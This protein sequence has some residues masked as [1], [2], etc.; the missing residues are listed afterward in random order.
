MKP[1][2]DA[3]IP[4]LTRFFSGSNALQWEQITGGTAPAT[5]LAS[6]TPWL[7][8]L[9]SSPIDRPLL[10]PVFAA[11]GTRRWYAIAANDQIATQLL[12]EVRAFIGPSFSRFSGH[13]HA[14]SD[15][16]D[17]ERVLKERFDW[18]VL[19]ID[20]NAETD[21]VNVERSIARY[22]DLLG[23]RPQIPD[24][25]LRPFA[26]VR[27]DFELALLAGNAERA[28]RF[29]DELLGSG[30]IG[31]DQHQF[32]RIR[33]LAGLG[34][35]EE[36]AHDRVLIASVMNLALPPQTLVDLVEGLYET[37]IEPRERQL[38]M[39]ALVA[40]FNQHL[41]RPFGALFR[42]RKGIRRPR[43]LRAF[44]LF[45]AGQ[46][47]RN[48]GRCGAIVETY[49][50]EDAALDL[51]QHWLRSIVP[52]GSGHHAERVRQAVA[53][54]DYP[55]ATSLALE[56]LPQ[57]WAY[58]AL[59]R[60]AREMESDELGAQL[61]EAVRH[62]DP[63]VLAALTERDRARHSRLTASATLPMRPLAE[64]GWLAWANEV[65]ARTD[66]WVPLEVLSKAVL[67]WDVSAYS[68]DPD[69][70]ARLAELIGNAVEPAARVFRDAFPYMVDFF[71][72]RLEKP[73]RGFIPLYSILIKVIAWSGSVSADELEI[74][75]SL[76][77]ALLAA[78]PDK[79]SYIECL[80]DL[81]EV[82]NANSAPIHLDWALSLAELLVLYPSH[83]PE[84]RLRLFFSIFGLCRAATHRLS[85]EQRAVL[86]LLA[87]DYGCPD[88]LAELPPGDR[89]DVADDPAAFAGLIGIYT[90]NEPAGQR[91]RAVIERLLPAV[92]VELNSDL[93]ASD[94]L[95]HL[96]RNADLFVFAWKTSTHQAFYCAKDA[97]KDR[98]IIMPSGGGTASLVKSVLQAVR[99]P[100]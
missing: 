12:E 59:L 22:R 87:T 39:S 5:W 65:T 19:R 23:Q 61:L 60:C 83:E 81:Q 41:S 18:R 6:V 24:R 91:A 79:A 44:F 89:G 10:L 21:R 32:L 72:E 90:L 70:C 34:R 67:K 57:P 26:V 58:S 15:S 43:V 94:R 54:E 68:T 56:A 36:L 20:L 80:E 40:L 3:E 97:R 95:R 35:I 73:I 78:G 63:I 74:G 85:Q 1:I 2:P 42:E 62:I 8:F 16:D 38:E 45:E 98:D 49:P 9:S 4:W 17:A 92:T 52:A 50:K 27:N 66:E 86:E 75:T 64:S 77:R 30:R 96:A 82:V 69:T 51:V 88:L 33:F 37:Y 7:G 84:L 76:T 48:D 25:A 29:L 46:Q 14:L 100:R 28:Q 13:W 11:D 47:H 99:S 53:D 71:V 93:A 55:L 31:A